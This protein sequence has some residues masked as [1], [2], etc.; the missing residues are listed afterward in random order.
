M[1][2]RNLAR[3]TFGLGIIGLLGTIGFQI[4]I[5]GDI[6]GAIVTKMQEHERR[7][8]S[9]DSDIRD[10]GSRT[11]VLGRDV[12][13]IKGKLHGI[14]SQVGRMPGKVAARIN[15]AAAVPYQAATED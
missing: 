14:S 6:K 2:D 13:E 3:Y 1:S 10:I 12:A 15:E 4:Y 7:L 9:H 5:A 8:E 11:D